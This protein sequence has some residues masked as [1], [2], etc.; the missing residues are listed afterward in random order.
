MA[1]SRGLLV[2][3]ASAGLG[4]APAAGPTTQSA[5]LDLTA[6]AALD[7][8]TAAFMT[9]G[10]RE[11]HRRET[12]MACRLAPCDLAVVIDEVC[13]PHRS[14]VDGA[15]IDSNVGQHVR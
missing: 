12:P 4:A 11:R 10:W 3:G 15:C 2:V 6:E 14:N 8:F 5:R 9:E 1:A 13:R 7:G